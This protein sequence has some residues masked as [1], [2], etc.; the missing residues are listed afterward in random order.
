MNKFRK[1]K[2]IAL[3]KFEKSDFF[4][5]TVLFLLLFFAVFF[6]YKNLQ[7]SKK[8]EKMRLSFVD[9]K[10]D[11]L[12]TKVNEEVSFV[13]KKPISKTTSLKKSI[14]KR[15]HQTEVK[16]D[17]NISDT[18]D[19]KKIYGIGSVFSNR[20]VKYRNLLGGYF[21]VSQ[22]K[23]VYGINDELYEKIK[24]KF[25]CSK[26]D[27]KKIDINSQTFKQLLKHPYLDYEEVKKIC[28]LRKINEIDSLESLKNNE[29][30]SAEKFNKLNYY[31]KV[32]KS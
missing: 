13:K 19:L 25:I 21:N 22:L 31:F 15:N 29:I 32:S 11:S 24:L 23:E 7:N 14:Q 30:V 20:I 3:F 28:D 17:L 1:N 27:I 2:F 6:K 26:T 4:G 12:K 5:L 10:V 16:I 8:T 18:S 9:I